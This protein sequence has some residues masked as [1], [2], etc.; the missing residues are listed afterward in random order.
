MEERRITSN[1]NNTMEGEVSTWKRCGMTKQQCK[2]RN[3]KSQWVATMQD[4]GDA[5]QQA[6]ITQDMGNEP[7]Q[8]VTTQGEGDELQ[9]LT[10]TQ[11]VK[12]QQRTIV[13][14]DGHNK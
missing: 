6:T 5:P 14:G 10:V 12:Q 2:A 8:V 9:Q 3:D 13:Q 1:N 7:Q 11:G 4:K